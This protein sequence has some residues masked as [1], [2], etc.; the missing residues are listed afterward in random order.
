MDSSLTQLQ[1]LSDFFR[2][3]FL[4][5]ALVALVFVISFAIHN[6]GVARY[7]ISSIC[8]MILAIFALNAWSIV[9]R[10]HYRIRV[11]QFCL[12]PAILLLLVLLLSAQTD[13]LTGL[14]N[15]TLLQA[16][17]D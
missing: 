11:I 10:N 17:L 7:L 14:L 15:R 6:F 12:V 3:S 9:H 1:S 8:W 13:P 2:K 5:L 16:T 4:R